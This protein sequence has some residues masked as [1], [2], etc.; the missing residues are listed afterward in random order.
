MFS[1]P[2]KMNFREIEPRC[3]F[4]R[5]FQ[6]ADDSRTNEEWGLLFAEVQVQLIKTLKKMIYFVVRF[7]KWTRN[8][9][10]GWVDDTEQDIWYFEQWFIIHMIAEMFAEVSWMSL[11]RLLRS[12]KLNGE[13]WL[14]LNSV[15]YSAFVNARD[16]VTEMCMDARRIWC[17]LCIH[18]EEE[19]RSFWRL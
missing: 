4:T 11:C 19:R 1:Q 9:F 10:D 8:S 2:I 16:F 14:W 12:S 6:L 3:V 17:P 7:T 18:G 15:E 5:N 13:R